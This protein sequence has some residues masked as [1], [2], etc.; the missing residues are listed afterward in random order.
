M[1]LLTVDYN[2]NIFEKNRS[3]RV[4]THLSGHGF[5]GFEPGEAAGRHFGPQL[6]E[7]HAR[8]QDKSIPPAE[9]RF[10]DVPFNSA[11]TWPPSPPREGENSKKQHTRDED[12]DWPN[13]PV[14]A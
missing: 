8:F 11:A 1:S 10:S 6:F 5:C 4:L 7:V 3:S 14:T 9:S 2:T 12:A 13:F